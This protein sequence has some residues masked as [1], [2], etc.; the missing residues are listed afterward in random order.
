MAA[1][2]SKKSDR[3]QGNVPEKYFWHY[4][5]GVVLLT[6]I[7][8]FPCLS[9]DFLN[10]DDPTFVLGNKNITSLSGENISN[11]FSSFVMGNYCPLSILSYAIDYKIAGGLGPKTFHVTALV[12]HLVN[13][14]LVYMFIY[15]LSNRQLMVA[16]IAAALFGVHP[17]HLES[18]AWIAE[19]R[20]VLYAMFY[21]L[22]LVWYMK[23]VQ[24]G[25][26]LKDLGLVLLFFVLSLLSKGQAVTFPLVL[27]VIDFIRRREFDRKNILEKVPFF[28]LSLVFGYIAIIAQKTTPAVNVFNLSVF[29][30]LFVGNY[31]LLLYILKAIVPFQL[32]GYHPYPFTGTVNIPLIIYA[33]PV[34]ILALAFLVYKNLRT[35]R[36]IVGG[37][38]IFAFT[39][40]P[41]LQ[42]LP[43][44]ETIISERYTYV[45]YLGL[46]FLAGH[47]YRYR[48][49]YSLLKSWSSAAPYV[50]GAWLLV[51]S[52]ITFG[53]TKV[54]KDSVTFWTDV[55]NTY[56]DNKIPYNNRGYMYNEFK[57]YDQAIADF[58]KG[59]SLDSAY[60]RLYLNRGL[61]FERK[62]MHAEAL[63]DYNA[64]ARLDTTE[65]Q[66]F[67][68]RGSMYTDIYGQYDLGIKDFQTV[69]RKDP[70]RLDAINNMGVAYFK[71]GDNAKALAQYELSLSK[72]PND[73]KIVYFRALVYAAQKEYDKAIAEAQRARQMG[74]A[75]DDNI[76]LQ[77]QQLKGAANTPV[78]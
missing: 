22:G 39:I 31:G 37:L 29:H 76:L 63:R 58:N 6:L 16:A 71:K 26:R 13:T 45:P 78:Q 28:A 14:L 24:N 43:V 17:L 57:Q 46:F 77:W 3:S 19:R 11:M 69:L 12:I 62:Q 25:Y 52:G 55:M 67:L 36:N 74:F 72:N 50:L 60:G 33:A 73:G 7:V 9:A 4:G 5:A 23:Y 20:D 68:N 35:D 49:K 27:V 18:V 47:A 53:R 64:A 2:A 41:V 56:P 15:Q 30:S 42:F 66:T 1:K 61:S 70:D 54:W 21:F 32:S 48:D 8:L 75:F 65:L 10:W 51:L 59:I 44:G 34:L 38:L 40:F